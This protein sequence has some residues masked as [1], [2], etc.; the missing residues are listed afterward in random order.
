V[1]AGFVPQIRVDK[2][3]YTDA[4]PWPAGAVD[5]GGLSL[6]RRSGARFGND[7]ESWLGAA[8]TAGA[9]N[10]AGVLP[11]V[12]THSPASQTALQSR[13]VHFHVGVE[14]AG[15]L[16]FQWRYNGFELSGE[17]RA[18]LTLDYVTL[19]HE[20]DYDVYVSN[21]AGSVFS[22]PARLTV[23]APPLILL[24]P[25]SVATNAGSNAVFTVTAS[26]SLP[27]FYQWRF[28]G[29]DLPGATGPT[30]LLSNVTL[31][32]MGN[33]SVLVSNRVAATEAAAFLTVWVRP[34]FLLQPVGQTVPAGGTVSFSA[35][36]TGTPP[37]GHRWRRGSV[38]LAFLTPTTGFTYVPLSNGYIWGSPTG[39]FLVLTNVSPG[40]AGNYTVVP[41]NALAQVVSANAPL[42]IVTD[43]DGD[44]LPDDWENTHAGFD[45]G[46]PSD[47]ARDADGDGLSN[48]AEHFAGTDYL[49]ATSY[50]RLD[51]SVAGQTT[52]H[53]LAVSNR[54]YTVEFTDGLP[55]QWQKLRDIPARTNSRPEAVWD[56]QPGAHR[57]YRLI[58][59]VQ[60]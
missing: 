55:P 31:A 38:N 43:T 3:D 23:D 21:P 60:P 39:S 11:P 28:N 14:G 37:L 36:W 33:Y 58:T 50:L 13:P 7:P 12:I 27:L 32:Q 26:G 16:Q 47:G 51:L 35:A 53:F 46:D 57:Y 17:T 56:F 41:S 9:V 34:T 15:P 19:D 22:E 18:E 44:G 52:L 10:G 1:G 2:V 29:V 20:G 48:A 59:P 25:Q 30:L 42:T 40:V 4:P 45:P 8:P 54:T 24:P 6:Q 5:G 49:D